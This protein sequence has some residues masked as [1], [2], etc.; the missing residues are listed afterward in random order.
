V[1]NPIV[2]NRDLMP[3]NGFPS[4]QENYG[5]PMTRRIEDWKSRLIDLSRRNNLLYFKPSKRGNLSVSSPN[6]ESIFNRLALRKRSLEFWYPP[7]EPEVSKRQSQSNT[8]FSLLNGKISPTAKQLVCEGT[9][10]SDLE[11][12]LKNLHRRSLLDYRG[13]P[14][15]P[16]PRTHRT[17]EKILPRALRCFSSSHRRRGCSESGFAS[18][19][20]K[21]LQS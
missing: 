12:V 1:S 6:M 3:E 19:A 16:C 2:Q 13:S 15:P 21:R 9:S 5:S 14:L 11:K 17:G 18:E 10:R 7:E 8:P 20:E 4:F